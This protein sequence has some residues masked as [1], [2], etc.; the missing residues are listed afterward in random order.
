MGLQERYRKPIFFLSLI[1]LFASL[2]CGVSV[3]IPFAHPTATPTITATVTP[4][5][6]SATPTATYTPPATFTP[7]PTNTPVPPTATFTLTPTFTQRPT[8]SIQQ[9]H[10]L[11]ELW[12]IVDHEYLYPDFNDLDWN[13]VFEEYRQKVQSGMTEENFYL[14][15]SEMIDRLGDNHSAFFSPEQVKEDNEQLQGAYNFVGVG[16]IINLVPERNRAAVVAVFPKSPAD[17]AGIK[18]HDSILE[19]NGKPILEGNI[20]RRADIRGPI[21]SPVTLTVQSPGG[22]A[23][24]V[25]LTRGQINSELPVPHEVLTTPDGQRIGY[26]LLTT[27]YD[28]TIPG[29]VH[30]AIEEM[31]ADRNLD[32]LILDN[33]QNTG[34]SSD[35]FEAVLSDFENGKVGNFVNRK[36]QE[37]VVV[38]GVDID[39]SQ[40]I[41]LVVLV[42]K[43]TVSFGEIFSGILKDT[44]RA[45]LIGQTTDGNVEIMYVYEFQDGSRAWIAHDR[46]QPLNN[47]EQNWEQTGIIPDLTVLSN[48]DEVTTQTDPVIQA[49]LKH[50]DQ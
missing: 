50:F 24:Q 46:F 13:A 35:V 5:P 22:E 33:R 25:E 29:K 48:W 4:L 2:A 40:K 28:E 27:F 43:D 32:G 34:G 36:G 20:D 16:V 49:A 26:I 44:R 6:P 47:P 14:A 11:T 41:P 8:A 42:G 30:Q 45:Y 18:I 9:L 17:K 7:S 39:G 15:M 1:L 21:G 10:V 19:V 38:K 37:P 31:S 3:Q 23:R 12:D